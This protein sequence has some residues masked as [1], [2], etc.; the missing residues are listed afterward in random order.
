MPYL[1]VLNGR[2]R[3]QVFPLGA[4]AVGAVL[5]QA[6]D[7]GVHLTDPWIS[8]THARVRRDGELTTIEDLGSTNGTYVN[9]ERVARRSLADDDVLFLGRTHILFVATDRPPSAPPGAAVRGTPTPAIPGVEPLPGV[10]VPGA[11]G[12]GES[13][14][15]LRMVLPGAPQRLTALE[16]SHES[17]LSDSGPKPAAGAI[18][19]RGFE[20]APPTGRIRG[21]FSEA[22]RLPELEWAAE[23]AEGL[24]LPPTAEVVLKGTASRASLETYGIEDGDFGESETVGELSSIESLDRFVVRDPPLSDDHIEI[25]IEELGLGAPERR[26]RSRESL[27]AVAVHPLDASGEAERLDERDAE[28]ERLRGLLAERDAEITRLRGELVNLREQ[29]LDL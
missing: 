2:H 12:R 10:A 24:A 5:G 6:D 26:S 13:T 19:A 15:R 20:E 21:P 18:A 27:E 9:C 16:A 22:G 1:Y 29:Y 14:Q 3:H 7:A 23:D 4:D 11:P 25:D 28:I 17:A 8:W